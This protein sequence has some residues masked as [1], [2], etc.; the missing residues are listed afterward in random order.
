MLIRDLTQSTGTVA[1]ESS[2][3]EPSPVCTISSLPHA[4]IIRNNVGQFIIVNHA[5]CEML[6]IRF[7]SLFV[8]D[9]NLLS[10]PY[11]R[12]FNVFH[13]ITLH[14]GTTETVNFL[15]QHPL[16]EEQHKKLQII[17]DPHSIDVQHIEVRPFKHQSLLTIKLI[18]KELGSI[19]IGFAFPQNDHLH[20]SHIKKIPSPLISKLC[21]SL[22]SKTVNEEKV[23]FTP[24]P[25]RTLV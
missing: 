12:R 5:L 8:T 20:Q 21:H 13:D 17:F 7:Y 3:S 23:D 16:S 24:L 9:D 15:L 22:E 11:V 4:S 14:R 1:W 18:P 6:M 10:S 2:I 25:N 19:K